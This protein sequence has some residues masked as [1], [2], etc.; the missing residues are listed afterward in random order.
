MR[1]KEISLTGKLGKGLTTKVSEESLQIVEH[2][3]WS[4]DKKNGY[5]RAN[6]KQQDG[7]YKTVRLH[8]LIIDCPENMTIDH[9]NGDKLDNRIENLRITTAENN[10]KN[11]GKY[12]NNTSGYKGVI[13]MKDR[14]KWRAVLKLNGR[15]IIGGNFED[16]LEAAKAYNELAKKY[17]G[18]YAQLN[19][20]KEEQQ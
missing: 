1:Y 9:I 13:W 12:S 19:D 11:K 6:V 2:Y 4:F 3:K 17:H 20:I 14:Q 15:N 16:K 8:R 10:A 7:T 18:E 5:A